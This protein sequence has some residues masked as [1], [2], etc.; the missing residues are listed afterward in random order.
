MNMLKK[1]TERTSSVCER[2]VDLNHLKVSLPLE[3]NNTL[4]VLC[5]M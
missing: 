5:I 2:I 4:T 1:R 3:E